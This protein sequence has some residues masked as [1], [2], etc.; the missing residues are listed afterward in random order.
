MKVRVEKI[1]WNASWKAAQARSHNRRKG[2]DAWNRR[3][4][5]F[6]RHQKRKSNYANQFL[7]IIKP[8]PDWQILDIGCGPGTLAV[9]LA[10]RVAS[11]TALD[12]SEVM[13]DLLKERCKQEGVTNVT[14]VLA[15]WED[16]WKSLGIG[17]HDMAIASRSLMD[18]DLQKTVDK[19]NRYSKQ[20]ACITFIAGDGPFDRR[21]FEAAG[22][23]F[24]PRPDYI[25]LVNLLHQMGIYASLSF[26]VHPD[27]RTYADHEDA[28]VASRWMLE[29]MTAQEKDRL[30]S[31][32]KR[33]LVYKE[34]EW[35]L[36]DKRIV[37][38]AVIW[39]DK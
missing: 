15:S 4:P 25:Y 32:L 11:V 29:P 27:Y 3:A 39:W 38:W 28:I 20:Q 10:R 34:G 35:A 24:H 6:A 31:W 37:R 36:P 18:G 26:T 5:S 16:D 22:R 1:D 2:A 30:M 23:P 13:L 14:P 17:A 12:F 33:N 21:I 9:P 8:K 19:L 7:E